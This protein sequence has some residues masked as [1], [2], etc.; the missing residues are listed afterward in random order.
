MDVLVTGCAGY[1]G[2]NLI[3]LLESQ[4]HGV[5]GVDVFPTDRPGD[6]VAD[7]AQEGVAADLVDG[8][9]VIIHTAAIHPWKPYTDN[10]YMDNNIRPVH[11]LLKAAV[12]KGVERV[13][14]TSSTSAIGYN[15]DLSE[16]P[17][18]EAAP[19]R[20]DELYGA[21][22]WFGEVLCEVASRHHSL[23]TVCLRPPA[24]MPKPQLERGC[25]LLGMY[26]DVSDVAAAHVAAITAPMPSRH[27]AFWTTNPLPYTA[28]D[29]QQLR[30]EPEAIVEKYWP[31]VPAWFEQ[32]ELSVRP[33]PVIYDL[34]RAR[35]VLGW[36]PQYS[37]D[38]WW[39]EHSLEC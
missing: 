34:S 24:F 35:E 16:L 1:L 37:F 33:V 11:H 38:T 32:R 14:Y 8:V 36:Q 6:L 22:K 12:D 30:T 9:E 4:G 3:P 25:M 5:R 17:L 31:G 2:S 10:Q 39:K 18:T 13:V 28:A 23:Q 27:E 21:T 19:A 29:G 7:L 26:A 20:P 15:P